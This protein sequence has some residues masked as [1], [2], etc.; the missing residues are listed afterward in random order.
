LN[1]S[2]KTE[3]SMKKYFFQLAIYFTVV[4]FSLTADAQKTSPGDSALYPNYILKVSYQDQLKAKVAAIEAK[5]G[6]ANKLP[7]TT[8][9]P[10]VL[11]NISN[12]AD[13]LAAYNTKNAVIAP[14]FLP[15]PY[16]T[17]LRIGE[18]RSGIPASQDQVVSTF[19]NETEQSCLMTDKDFTNRKNINSL[20]ARD[21]IAAWEIETAGS[22]GFK[23]S[24][25][26][27]KKYLSVSRTGG[28]GTEKISLTT[29]RN[30]L[31]TNWIIYSGTDD[32]I[33]FYNPTYNIFL[34]RRVQDR[35]I[36]L[37]PFS[38]KEYGND[39]L[40]KVIIINWDLYNQS[41]VPN[42]S[43]VCFENQYCHSMRYILTRPQKDAD[44]DGS[45][46]KACGGD[47]CDDNDMI[48][49][50]GNT[51]I[52]DADGHDEDCNP[53]TGGLRDA[54]GD[55][56]YDY[57]CF[58]IING[59]IQSSGIDCDD[60]NPAIFPGQQI[61]VNETTVDVCG[62]GIFELAT[63]YIAVKQPN[64]TAIVIPKK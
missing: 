21:V 15:S 28:A 16:R 36:Y 62:K 27:T 64:G 49:F 39:A 24:T 11:K 18:Y 20:L 63:G 4:F 55:G 35:K 37:V 44:L 58:N 51:E 8:I 47:D 26:G 10:L 32:G 48:K 33:T 30:D 25:T 17:Y 61:F 56:Y 38:Y 42:E 29:D 6:L 12:A 3:N 60:N 52:C 53:T 9:S 54:D 50:P 14:M 43:K 5:K 22:A 40:R 59:V 57:K 46:S 19:F 23:I 1:G 31:T 13:F 34:G 41:A 2:E 45:I 7:G